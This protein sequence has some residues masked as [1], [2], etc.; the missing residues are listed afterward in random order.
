MHGLGAYRTELN[1]YRC[2]QSWGYLIEF[3]AVSLGSVW[4]SI[5]CRVLILNLLMSA[6][7]KLR[8]HEATTQSPKI[9]CKCFTDALFTSYSYLLGLGGPCSPAI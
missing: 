6:F 8:M 7:P 9:Y 5:S 3:L 1:L 2:W 4:C